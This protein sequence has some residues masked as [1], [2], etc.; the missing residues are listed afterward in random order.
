MTAGRVR[1]TCAHEHIGSV[2][3]YVCDLPVT[4]G[5]SAEFSAVVIQDR[6]ISRQHARLEME[7]Q[8]LVVSDLDSAN[9]TFV[10][11]ERIQRRALMPEDQIR[12]G[13]YR[14]TWSFVDQGLDETLIMTLSPDVRKTLLATTL[15]SR[16]FGKI[17]ARKV[18]EAAERYNRQVGH[19]NEGFLSAAHGFLPAEAPLLA[20]PESHRAWDDL[21]ERL[22][23]LYR[24]LSMR[25]ALDE[26]P[27]LEAS[28]EALA[29]RYLLRASSLLGV[30]AHAYQYV[31]ID[32]PAALPPPIVEPWREVSRRLGKPVPYVSYT[33]LFLYNWKL[34]DPAG[35]RRLDNMD[36]LVPAWNNQA[37]RIFNLV[38]T[39][40]AMQLTP[41]FNAM[42]GAQEA[43]KKD[44]QG[45]VEEALLIILDQLRYVTQV[46]YPQIDSNPYSKTH[47][48]QV[49]W[50]KTVGMSGVPIFEGAPSPSGTAQPHIHALDAFFERQSYE[51]LVGKQSVLLGAQFPRHWLE[52]L[53]A[54]RAISVRQ[55][56]ERKGNSA[57]QGLYNAALD[58][59]I[60][61]KGWMGLHRI[62]AYSFLEVAFKVGR[63]VTTG[64]KFT[65]L[66]KDKTWDK[67]DDELAAVR[68]ERYSASRQQVYFARPR[69]GIVTTDAASG[70]WSTFLELDVSGQGIQYLPGDR[71]GVLPENSDALVR[72]TLRALQAKGSELVTL[73][74]QW[75][76]ALRFRPGYTED[77]K[78]LP[79]ESVLTFG[80]IRPVTRDIS[81]RLLTVSASPALKRIVDAR[82]EDQ[83]E[84][85]DILNLLYAGGYDVTQLWK[86]GPGDPESICRVVPP[87]V[88]RLYSIA[89]AMDDTANG[90]E[91]LSLMV[92]GL[93]YQTTD[94]A[95]SYAQER[96]GT[97][98][99]FLRTVTSDPKYQSKR[100]SL[101][102]VP[103]PRFRLPVDP[104]RPVVMFAAGSGIAP[105]YGFLQARELHTET[106]ENWLFLGTRTPE[107][108]VQ[109]S[110]FE[111]L[112][113]ERK[114]RL[115]IAFSRADITARFDRIAGQYVFEPG[116][117]QRIGDLLEGDEEAEAIWRLLRRLDDGGEEGYFYVC[118]KTTFAVAV[119]DALRAVIRRVSGWSE[120]KVQEFLDHLVADGRYM[121]DI[122]TTYSGHAQEGTFYDVSQVVLHNTAAD[123]YWMAVSGK[124]YDVS[125]FLRQHV[126]GERILIHYT[127]MDAT[128][129]YQTVLHHVNS[130]VD[131]L[132][133]MFELGNM[134]RLRFGSGWGVILSSQGL[135]FMLLEELFV[136]WVRYIYLVV[137]MENAIANDYDFAHLSSTAGEDPDDVSPFK[138][139]FLLEAHRRFLVSYLDGLIDEDLGHLWI[140]TVGFCAKD[141]DVRGLESKIAAL[142]SQKTYG[143]A[144]GAVSLLK[145][146]VGQLKDSGLVGGRRASEARIRRLCQHFE[147]DDKQVLH[148]IKMELREGIILFER[149]EAGVIEKA[150][151]QL[152]ATLS[153][154]LTAV[155][156]YYQRI[157]EHLIREGIELPASPDEAGDEPIPEDRGL[158]GHGG[159]I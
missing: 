140:L 45:A 59:Y 71:I 26:L 99:T 54:L 125:R 126:G 148:D 55:Y 74:A 105:F 82:M 91:K 113:A 108:F 119:L 136:A 102:I 2:V 7:G 46:I 93:E 24:T 53:E 23:E 137:G 33:D 153:R 38:T 131:A 76:E 157:A 48:D 106:G 109:R 57:L 118:G 143:V 151:Q 115:H 64:A 138:C 35:P 13:A 21:I 58:A 36:L 81:K 79:L 63:S 41:A 89:S 5:R 14:F 62:K 159:R 158:P 11:D 94:T 122:F 78:V 87:E 1:L 44:D 101:T 92:A 147:N 96:E 51:T 72:K 100:L 141:H 39:E 127:G 17:P 134:R 149:H 112:E 43:V 104:S 22:P 4:I 77:V 61:D 111:R 146:Q 98:S 129:A 84:L 20:L 70:M 34:R 139:Q 75:R 97:A 123:G 10:N 30:L 120:P 117:R 40:F 32:P 37:E 28:R 73:S 130:E 27:I 16:S 15:S 25:G 67:I 56:I 155:D 152:L 144:R 86:A 52:F 121:Q 8:Q 69:R 49:L 150:S 114:L 154:T 47:L 90:A 31:E 124:V 103:A 116:R 42:I 135:K 145:Q 50:A 88:F 60:G 133:G 156:E 95:H 142:K 85:W 18:V 110:V 68:D 9:G 107:E 66:F 12:I 29:D 3:D 132:L 128:D 6:T 80:K 83:W 65:G 19:E